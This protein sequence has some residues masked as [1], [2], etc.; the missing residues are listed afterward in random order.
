M[1]IIQFQNS[2]AEKKALGW[3]PGRFSFKTWKNGDMMVHENV[4]AYLAREGVAFTVI[5]PA[6]YE[7]FLPEIRTAHPVAV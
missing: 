1:V 3:L 2:D 6:S 7:R 4:L 5:G